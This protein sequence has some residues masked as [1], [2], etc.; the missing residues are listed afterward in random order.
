MNGT[1]IPVQYCQRFN[2]RQKRIPLENRW[3]EIS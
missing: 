3:N 2:A 1:I